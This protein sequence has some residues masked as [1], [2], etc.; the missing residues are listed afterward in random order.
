MDI[1]RMCTIKLIIIEMSRALLSALSAATVVG[2]K[3][4]AMIGT[5]AFYFIWKK[6]TNSEP[7][8]IDRLTIKKI[9]IMLRK[10]VYSTLREISF[11]VNNIRTLEGDLEARKISE[12]FMR[13]GGSVWTM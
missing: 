6:I 2:G 3:R 5:A 12:I 13:D 8:L 4:E 1:W 7:A 11:I 10:K 9:I